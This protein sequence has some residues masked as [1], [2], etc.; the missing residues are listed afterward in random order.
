LALPAV[1]PVTLCSE[2]KS[3]PFRTISPLAW[4]M[5]QLG[6]T[7]PEPLPHP[8]RGHHRLY[9]R[10]GLDR[11]SGEREL[12]AWPVGR[13]TKRRSVQSCA[14][15]QFRTAGAPITNATSIRP[16][17][18]SAICSRNPPSEIGDPHRDSASAPVPARSRPTRSVP[19]FRQP[20]ALARAVRG[21]SR[22]HAER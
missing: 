17:A 21:A 3:S 4:G 16:L 5:G 14:I 18:M 2:K 9:N 10:R 7:G 8:E 15:A 12:L 19:R 6:A 22:R 20:A 13:A 11:R 1:G